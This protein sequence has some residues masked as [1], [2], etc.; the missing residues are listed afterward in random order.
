MV[1]YIHTSISR[2]AFDE[3]DA[4]LGYIARPCFQKKKNYK[5]VNVNLKFSQLQLQHKFKVSLGYVRQSH[6]TINNNNKLLKTRN[7]FSLLYASF[8]EP[9]S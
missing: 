7:V 2:Y 3:F 5:D 4:S 9:E 6:K 1:A 8:L